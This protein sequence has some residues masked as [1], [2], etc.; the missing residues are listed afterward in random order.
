MLLQNACTVFF[1]KDATAS[2]KMDNKSLSFLT[3]SGGLEVY[4]KSNLVI[5]Q[6]HLFLV[7]AKIIYSVIK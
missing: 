1:F 7:G 5:S 2:V 4:V 6:G 3:K